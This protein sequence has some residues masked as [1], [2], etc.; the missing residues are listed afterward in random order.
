MDNRYRIVRSVQSGGGMSAA[1][2]H[3]FKLINGGK[4]ALMTIYQQRQYDM[5]RW[6]IRTGM[7]WI[8]ESIFQEVD[9]ETSEVLFE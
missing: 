8:M 1:D 4:T 9:V 3:E 7:A 5:S 2:M 6:N